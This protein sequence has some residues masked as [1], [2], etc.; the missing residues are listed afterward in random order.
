MLTCTAETV[1]NDIQGTSEHCKNRDLNTVQRKIKSIF[2]IILLHLSMF[3][4][5]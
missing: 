5:T 2:I 1:H 3:D 4:V